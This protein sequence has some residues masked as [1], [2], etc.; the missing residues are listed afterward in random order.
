MISRSSDPERATPT[1]G[2]HAG[3]TL[4]KQVE[5]W[6][7]D[8][9]GDF[10]VCRNRVPHYVRDLCPFPHSGSSSVE[11]EI[12]ISSDEICLLVMDDKD[13]LSVDDLN[14]SSN[15]ESR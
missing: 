5:D 9:I 7:G 14:H 15:S 13:N 8:R 2:Y 11:N 12:V 10:P 1:N 4:A 6:D 3:G